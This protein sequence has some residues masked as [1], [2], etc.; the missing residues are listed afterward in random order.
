MPIWMHDREYSLRGVLVV[1]SLGFEPFGLERPPPRKILNLDL[2]QRFR[3][4]PGTI[5]DY[6]LSPG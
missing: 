5:R 4:D 6:A 2:K 1:E 3:I